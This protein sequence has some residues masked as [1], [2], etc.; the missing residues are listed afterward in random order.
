MIDQNTVVRVGYAQQ[1]EITL[2]KLAVFVYEATGSN[3]GINIVFT[4]EGGEFDRNDVA[5]LMKR[6]QKVVELIL[7]SDTKEHTY[8]VTLDEVTLKTGNGWEELQLKA[9][10]I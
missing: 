9:V 1:Q 6:T 4:K 3:G 5:E 7:V 2:G 10:R 8:T